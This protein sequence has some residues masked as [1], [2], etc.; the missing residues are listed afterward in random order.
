VSP[1]TYAGA[2]PAWS[3]V[4]FTSLNAAFPVFVTVYVHVTVPPVTLLTVP[5]FTRNSSKVSAPPSRAASYS[6]TM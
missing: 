4:T 3:S 2:T 1:L 5:E 6:R